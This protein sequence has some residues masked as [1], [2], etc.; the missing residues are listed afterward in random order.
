MQEE[1]KIS[2][3]AEDMLPIIKKWLYSEHDIF[4][5]ELI[6][7]AVDAITKHEHFSL[8]GEASQKDV[9]YKIEVAVNETN[10]TIH[11]K[12]NG[13]GMTADEVKKYITQLAFSGATE[14]FEKYQAGDES[15]RMIGHFGLG[16]YSSFMVANKVEIK[17]LSFKDESKP[18]HWVCEGTTDYTLTEID[19]I[20]QHGTEIILHVI[21]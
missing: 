21:E 6:S 20:D 4:L 8:T 12:D 2:V 13:V 3:T 5:R 14:F 10:K 17:T 11:I 9:E 15:S 19:G 18:V 1:G 16:F 7:N